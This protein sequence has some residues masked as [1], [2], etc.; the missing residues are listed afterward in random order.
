M[1]CILDI[2]K[3][4]NLEFFKVLFIRRLCNLLIHLVCIGVQ[5]RVI[6]VCVHYVLFS[7][8]MSLLLE[9]REN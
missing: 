9:V 6:F 2:C 5:S 4:N 8:L 3:I 1:L 7:C